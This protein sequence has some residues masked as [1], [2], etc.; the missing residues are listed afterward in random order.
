V[1]V[2]NEKTE[3]R[4]AYLKIEIEPAEIEAQTETSYRRLVKRVNVPGFRRG[5]APRN[6]FERTFGK[7][8]LFHE[9]LDDLVPEAYKKAIDE[10]KLEPIAQ[11]QIEIA[12]ENP[13]VLKAVVPLK[14]VVTLGD[15]HAIEIKPREV[16]VTDEMVDK[17]VEQLR[18]QHATWEPVERGVEI[19]DM[20][21]IDMESTAKGEPFINRKGLEYRLLDEDT[22]P[23]PGFAG[24]LVGLKK[25]EEKE[26]SHKFQDDYFRKE[27]TGAD[28]S[29]K[30]K[31]N[32]IKR[33]VMPE[34]TDDFAKQV[35]S[36]FTTVDILRQKIHK[37][38]KERTEH[39]A[40]HEFEDQV[41]AAATGM[42]QVEYPPVILE[43]EIDHLLERN[44]RYI[45]QTGQ[46]LE[47]YL[48]TIG[49]TVDQMRDELRPAAQTRVAESLVLG[50][51][52]EEEKTE[53]TPAE[54]DAEIEEMVKNSQGDKEALKKALNTEQNRESLENTLV[55]RKVLKRL[56]EISQ[57]PREKKETA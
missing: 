51:I 46:D 41:I 9:M 19:T 29:F 24:Q 28:A 48:K 20:V 26:F 30:I 49:K 34:V 43:A 3:N 57:A 32:E 23:V 36:E 8:R 16:N 50:K 18:H 42:S 7:D 33:E 12:E 56:T 15:Y 25:G 47:H 17:V 35:N 14:P 44:F 1:K 27:L 11:P 39:E 22:G 31:V 55:T 5:K 52:A 54:I 4:Q 21:T 38:L 2:T 6:V 40:Q 13:V 53:V 37:E 10:Q 45:Q